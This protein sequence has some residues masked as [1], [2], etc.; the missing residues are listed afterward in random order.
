MNAAEI[1]I[2]EERSSRLFTE[3]ATCGVLTEF[4]CCPVCEPEKRA[5]CRDAAREVERAEFDRAERA[6]RERNRPLAVLAPLIE[7]RRDAAQFVGLCRALRLGTASYEQQRLAQRLTTPR[8]MKRAT[9]K[10]RRK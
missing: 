9:P 4:G 7:R 8:A 5:A 6:R 1:A 3:C 10:E 2:Q